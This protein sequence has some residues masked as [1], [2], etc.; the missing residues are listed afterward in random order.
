MRCAPLLLMAPLLITSACAN[1]QPSAEESAIGV[2]RNSLSKKFEIQLHE[3]L[4]DD[5]RIFKEHGT[6]KFG[7]L[8][9]GHAF[10]E[11]D[12]LATR[13]EDIEFLDPFGLVQHIESQSIEM[14]L[15]DLYVHKL[16]EG[17][18]YCIL[19]PFSGLGSSG[20]FQRYAALIAIKATHT[21]ASRPAGA[22]IKRP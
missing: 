19:S 2:C 22:I 10:V 3:S 4:S 14:D 21:G 9:D 1:P 5:E 20:S 12:G 7:K 13:V 8:N 11:A 18:V 15:S 6:L 16:K 17:S